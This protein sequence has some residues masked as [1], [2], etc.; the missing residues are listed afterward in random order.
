[1][2]IIIRL[3]TQEDVKGERRCERWKLE[4]HSLVWFLHLKKRLVLKVNVKH[5]QSLYF[6]RINRVK[7]WNVRQTSSAHQHKPWRLTACWCL[8]LALLK[9]R[10]RL[11]PDF[12]AMRLGSS[13]FSSLHNRL[14]VSCLVP[15]L[16][17][18]TH[19]IS[20]AHTFQSQTLKVKVFIGENSSK[21]HARKITFVRNN[22]VS[23][24]YATNLLF[25]HKD[26]Q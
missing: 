21:Q 15:G 9:Q 24:R 13:S 16:L 1:M 12:S 17:A 14:I 25:L 10:R 11:P 8:Y 22:L 26:W 3:K 23:L 19:T 4:T 18:S 6:Q 7:V 2:S 20:Q 5:I